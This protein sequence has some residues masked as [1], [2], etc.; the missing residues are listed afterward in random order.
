MGPFL[1]SLRKIPTCIIFP[2]NLSPFCPRTVDLYLKICLSVF[3]RFPGGG[4]FSGETRYIL[5]SIVVRIV[6]TWIIYNIE[7]TLLPHK[8][9][10]PKTG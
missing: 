4:R 5:L 8:L 2:Q 7:G 1:L 6:S 3:E 10:F 9:Q